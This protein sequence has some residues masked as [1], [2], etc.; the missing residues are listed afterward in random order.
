MF[1]LIFWFYVLT[2]KKLIQ[3]I[4]LIECALDILIKGVNYHKVE[5]D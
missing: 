4:T 5:Q 2:K 3:D 1:S